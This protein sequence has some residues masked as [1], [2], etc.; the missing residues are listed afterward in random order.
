[1]HRQK[2]RASRTE[3]HF[4][5][6]VPKMQPRHL[7]KRV[8]MTRTCENSCAL[9]S[10]WYV[11]G[12]EAQTF[13]ETKMPAAAQS[14]KTAEAEAVEAAKLKNAAAVQQLTAQGTL[15]KTQQLKA[16]LNIKM[17]DASGSIK[18]QEAKFAAAQQEE[19]KEQKIVDSLTDK[20]DKQQRESDKVF[21]CA[22]P[23][24]CGDLSD[25]CR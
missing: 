1:M 25:L 9:L 14:I 6:L 10:I 8:H 19:A 7:T 4:L 20:A 11:A 21:D 2:Q 16:A 5:K 18:E 15:K 13:S 17:K 3:L 22:L 23:V 12:Q 24:Q